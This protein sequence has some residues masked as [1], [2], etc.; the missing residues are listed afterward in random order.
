MPPEITPD[1]T[2][3]NTQ[4]PVTPTA[5]PGV[6][7]QAPQAQPQP[8]KAT[9]APAPADDSALPEW[10]QEEL[11]KARAESAERRVKLRETEARLKELEPLAA[12]AREAEEAQ[13]TEAEKLREQLEAVR[14]EQ[15]KAQA[16]AELKGK[17]VKLLT[18]ATKAGVS[19]DVVELLDLSKLDLDNEEATLATLKK[20]SSIKVTGGGASNPAG[21]Q[22]TGPTEQELRFQYFGAGRSNRGLIFGGNK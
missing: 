12:K 18:L 2:Q 11:K 19:P 20:L 1:T 5:V 22:N 17:Q 7:G 4:Q 16:E 15:L 14:A 9:P 13:K 3:G 21:T 6:F 8:A 10:A